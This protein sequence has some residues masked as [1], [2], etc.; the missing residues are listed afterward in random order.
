[1]SAKPV[2]DADSGKR[3]LNEPVFAHAPPTEKKAREGKKF[4]F[5]FKYD[6][7]GPLLGYPIPIDVGSYQRIRMALFDGDDYV[8]QELGF[9]SIAVAIFAGLDRDC[10]NV[11]ADLKKHSAGELK[12]LYKSRNSALLEF[13]IKNINEKINSLKQALGMNDTDPY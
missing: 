6:F 8:R 4:E 13:A 5:L 1:M 10:A 7:S 2:D 11:Y 9:T 12:V 3:A